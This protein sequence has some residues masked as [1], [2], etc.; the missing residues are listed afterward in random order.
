MHKLKRACP[1]AKFAQKTNA[2]PHIIASNI[3][4]SLH[5]DLTDDEFDWFCNFVLWSVRSFYTNDKLWRIKLTQ[6]DPRMFLAPWIGREVDAFLR[7]GPQQYIAR[8]RSESDISPDP[9]WQPGGS[10]LR[11]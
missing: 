10:L 2:L 3:L 7:E 9:E 8:M 11:S 1:E 6:K 4:R 5:V